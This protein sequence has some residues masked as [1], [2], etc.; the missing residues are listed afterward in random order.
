MSTYSMTTNVFRLPISPFKQLGRLDS[1]RVKW[2]PSYYRVRGE[3]MAENVSKSIV[4]LGIIL[5]V[6]LI[7]MTTFA[8]IQTQ[9]NAYLEGRIL[10]L[11]TELTH[12]QGNYSDESVYPIL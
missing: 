7:G 11:E 8:V 1:L 6:S 3:G 4:V 2:C 5:S 12:L 10:D 9:E